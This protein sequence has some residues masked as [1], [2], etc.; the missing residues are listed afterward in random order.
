[1][2]TRKNKRF[3][4]KIEDLATG[5]FMIIETAAKNQGQ[6]RTTLFKA[7][8]PYRKEI[9]VYIKEKTHSKKLHT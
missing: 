9:Q 7:L 3:L 6:L 4:I 5:E 1:M 8:Y 2:K